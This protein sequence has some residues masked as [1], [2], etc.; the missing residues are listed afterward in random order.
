MLTAKVL[1]PVLDGGDW[2]PKSK[3]FLK[4]IQAVYGELQSIDMAQD[5]AEEEGDSEIDE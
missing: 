3:A 2:S 4:Y 1:E 5:F